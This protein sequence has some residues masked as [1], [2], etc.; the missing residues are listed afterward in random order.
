MTIIVFFFFKDKKSP[1]DERGGPIHG[2]Q[3]S[4][5]EKSKQRICCDTT[6]YNSS[7]FDRNSSLHTVIL[8]I[9]DVLSFL[10]MPL[11][12]VMSPRGDV[13][14]EPPS[15]RVGAIRA[16]GFCSADTSCDSSPVS[17]DL[18][19]TWTTWIQSLKLRNES[20]VSLNKHF[21]P[22]L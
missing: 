6:F 22:S 15:R 1:E 14:S 13:G 9:L 3:Q 4:T 5:C 2:C 10:K 19:V 20:N 21:S 11:E 8:Q 18:E 16:D 7:L 12:K 17:S